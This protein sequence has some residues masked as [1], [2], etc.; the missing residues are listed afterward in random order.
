VAGIVNGTRW[1]DTQ[2]NVISAHGGG[3][4]YKNGYFYWFGENR[5]KD[6]L[7]S[8]YRS[9]DL[10]VWEFCNHVVTKNTH[11]ELNPS[12]TERPKVIYNDQTGKYVMWLHWENGIHYGEARAAVL[13]SDTIDG[14]YT[15]LRSFRPLGHMSRDCTLFKDDD[16]SAY[17]ISAARENADLHVY[18]LTD[19][20]LDIA[21]LELVLWPGQKREAPALTKRG[22][23][24]FLLTSGCTGWEPNQGMYAYSTSITGQWSELINIGTATTFD[25][26]P[27]YILQ[28]KGSK[29]TNY[30][31][32]GDRW[33]P[34]DYHNS[35][36]AFLPLEFPTDTSMAVNWASS[37]KV[38]VN[39]GEVKTEVNSTNLYRLQ[40]NMTY[41]NVFCDKYTEGTNISGSR[42][43]Y[44]D[45]NQLWEIEKNADHTV[46]FKHHL[47]QLYL[48]P[49]NGSLENGAKV[50]LADK[51]EHL[52]QVWTLIDTGQ[53]YV[54]LQN[55]HS[56]MALALKR[57]PNQ[58]L[59][60]TSLSP[61]KRGRWD[62]QAFLLAEVYQ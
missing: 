58:L 29:E 36:Y 10:A 16:G 62:E 35:T 50:V 18:R 15:Y 23:Y 19:D 44:A 31:Y 5:H 9:C 2:G 3:F 56:K 42:L 48:E 32:V 4:L 34:S 40:V 26:Q 33:D 24:Y 39:T 61:E 52:K 20:Y 46:R 51:A 6:K 41:L 21:A 57:G 59:M 55:N 27:T 60:Q 28:I 37:V 43:S 45:K 1:K 53:G 14:D 12:N 7:I 38:N 30:L 49:D 25:T 47:S 11:L 54:K 13:V 22:N 17:F 8:C